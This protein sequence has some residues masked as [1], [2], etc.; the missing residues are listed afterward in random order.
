MAEP[1][2]LNLAQ[3]IKLLRPYKGRWWLATAALLLASVLRLALPQ[4]V[5]IAI[6]DA[7]H[8]GDTS[9]L[10]ILV[11]AG[12]VV[13]AALG[14]LSFLRSYL[15]G[16]LGGR[17]VADIRRDT[18]RHLLRHSPGFYHLRSSGELLSR[19][20]SDIGM[21][22]FAV[23]AEISIAIKS[24][25]IIVGGLA[26]L[27]YTDPALTLVMVV[28]AP[29]VAL[30]AVWARRR[31]RARAREIQ[32]QVAKANSRL[33]EAIVGIETVQAFT[34]EERE[35]ALYTGRVEKAWSLSVS[36]Y[37]V[38]GTF[39]GVVQFLGYTAIALIM[40][41]G[42]ERVITGELSAGELA[43]F[44]LYTFMV[45]EG[46]M[47]LAQVWANLQRAG[48]ATERIFELLDTEPTIQDAEGAIA[49]P[50]LRGS[51]AFESVDFYYATRPDE[52]VL[53]DVSFR[54]EPGEVVALVGP[55]GAGK[56]TIS[57]LIHRFHDPASGRVTVDG[58][59]LREVRLEDLRG[60]IATVHQE[61]MLFSGPVAEN[62]A[63]GLPAGSA[64]PEQIA[65]AA[66]DACIAEF[67]E[68]LKDGYGTE[69]GE[70]GVRL[71]GGQ[72][73]RIAIARALIA[74]PRILILDEATSHLDT[75]NEAEVQIALSRL[76]KGRT[77][78]VIAH[79]LSTVRNV[80]R[81]LV[82]DGGR[83]VEEGSHDE[84]MGRGGIYGDLV[85]KQVLVA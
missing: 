42:G 68:G 55:S 49:L 50:E 54:I 16:W 31:I 65:Q 80:D 6:D 19:L 2:R 38:R 8:A 58:H 59:D 71:S 70:R 57:A 11:V 10:R 82:I 35:S 9:T 22:S 13:F 36:L 4:P 62:I 84:L 24:A 85:A 23:G 37:I 21:I 39:F 33:K 34:A 64:S 61:P 27:L 41:F 1:T 47:G 75:V 18:F 76:M 12:L 26:L 83:V 43:A 78:L 81:I 45:T 29:P 17:V 25:L 46:L 52:Q 79:R 20:T 14:L 32:D 3:I 72:R 30:G 15:V 53:S 56:S 28:T 66:R 7:I 77:T 40:W 67:I 44:L 69:V 5:R 48:G 60:A 74:D 51:L 63:Y 73:Q